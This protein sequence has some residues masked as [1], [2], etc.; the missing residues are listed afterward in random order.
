MATGSFQQFVIGF[1]LMLVAILLAIVM[2]WI[3][4]Q[5]IDGFYGGNYMPD[6]VLSYA[7]KTEFYEAASTMGVELYYI[8][9]FYLMCFALPIL[10]VLLFWQSL[11]KY[12]S[13]SVY[14]GLAGSD[15]TMGSGRQR[16]RRRRNR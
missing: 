8:N 12:Q 13:A 5:L 7:N 9:L 3:G 14:A 10:G 11:F 15:G 1:S 16:L 4:G 2:S 6:S